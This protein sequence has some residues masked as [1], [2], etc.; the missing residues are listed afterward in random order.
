MMTQ[1]MTQLINCYRTERVL[2]NKASLN[3]L[4]IKIFVS[5]REKILEELLATE[6]KYVDDL[7]SV[8][9][10][11]RSSI[12]IN[13]IIMFMIVLIVILVMIS[14]LTGSSSVTFLFGHFEGILFLPIY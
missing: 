2:C 5:R 10:G 12:V 7:Q 1:I 8:L 3:E 4:Q 13:V 14:V 6:E 11:C 9:T